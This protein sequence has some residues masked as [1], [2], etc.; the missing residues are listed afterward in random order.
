MNS[1]T[2]YTRIVRRA[3]Y[4]RR[5]SLAF[6]LKSGW[7]WFKISDRGGWQIFW[8]FNS[9]LWAEGFWNTP[10][11]TLWRIA[12]NYHSIYMVYFWLG[13]VWSWQYSECR[14]KQVGSTSVPNLWLSYFIPVFGHRVTHSTGNI[15]FVYTG[16]G[17]KLSLGAVVR[18]WGRY[19]FFQNL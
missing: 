11:M 15:F 7:L 4:S 10:N 8:F 18:T 5:I 1:R 16:A 2:E 13:R 6:F 12:R 14:L 3:M 9:Y 17:R 19:F